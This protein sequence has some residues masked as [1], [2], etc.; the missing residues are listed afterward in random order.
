MLHFI[1]TLISEKYFPLDVPCNSLFRECQS[2]IFTQQTAGMTAGMIIDIQTSKACGTNMS[3]SFSPVTSSALE[4][5]YL[6]STVS[7]IVAHS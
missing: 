1:V 5:I 4:L 7:G 3:F 6:N 2:W